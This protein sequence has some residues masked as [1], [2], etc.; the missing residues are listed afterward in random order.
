MGVA[1]GCSGGAG[2]IGGNGGNGGGAHGGH[3]L[4]MTIMGAAPTIDAATQKSI[5]FG[6]KG[7]GGPGGN[8][9]ADMNHGEDGL[10][11]ACW[12]FA[13]NKSCL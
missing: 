7:A 8:M 6:A 1:P 4:A 12:D 13:G 11:A 3:S 10:A 5:V 2:G 9:D